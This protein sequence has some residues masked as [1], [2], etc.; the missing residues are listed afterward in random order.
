MAEAVYGSEQ[1]MIRVD[2]SEYMEKHSVSRLVGAPPGYVGHEQGG[3]FCE[4]V[5]R[6]PYSL[7]LLDELEKAHRDVCSI[8]LQVMEDGV[9][10]DSSGRKVDFKNTLLIMTSNLGS[11]ELG[12]GVRGFGGTAE[13][14][15][16]APLRE[17]F[18]PEFLGRI[19]C[20]AS[21]RPLD[22]EILEQIGHLQL[23]RLE[24]RAKKQGLSLSFAPEL[25]PTLAQRAKKNTGGARAIRHLIQNELEAPLADLLLQE[26]PPKTVRIT[27][28][29]EKFCLTGT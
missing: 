9:L 20:I 18:P 16:T 19:D 11:R 24:E 28:E 8:L 29:G 14:T 22:T 17:H 27:T 7:I 4:R 1:A 6:R 5:R 26:H 12:K 13:G 21:F 3:E 15:V 10:T 23:S 25:Y 2:M